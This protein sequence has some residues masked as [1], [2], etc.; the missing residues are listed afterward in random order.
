MNPF[1]QRL[2]Q[3]PR[4]AGV[5]L[6]FRTNWHDIALPVILHL[7]LGALLTASFSFFDVLA[8]GLVFGGCFAWI[9]LAAHYIRGFK[10]FDTAPYAAVLNAILWGMFP[11]GSIA[12]A[13]V[14]A[15]HGSFTGLVDLFFSYWPESED[16]GKLS[17]FFAY[18]LAVLLTIFV[19]SELLAGVLDV[20]PLSAFVYWFVAFVFAYFTFFVVL[21]GL[22]FILPL[23][24]F[25]FPIAIF[26]IIVIRLFQLLSRFAGEIHK[27]ST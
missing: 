21:L 1:R 8:F 27:P 10:N 26:V 15:S 20:S 25:I 17:L 4:R 12:A 24:I 13:A 11:F 18:Q 9:M 5:A 19:L 3:L 6:R 7:T 16:A 23:S 14:V 2:W 22:F